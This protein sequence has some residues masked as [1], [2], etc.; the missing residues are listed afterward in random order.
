MVSFLE[1]LEAAAQRNQSLLCVGLD[2]S[3]PQMPIDDIVTFNRAIVEATSDLVCAFKPNI[4]FYEAE[5]LKGLRALE[6]T[7]AAIPGHIPVI[8]DAKRGDIGNSAAA[9]AKAAFERWGADAMTVNAYLGGDSVEPFVAYS[10]RGVFILCRTSNP[11]AAELQALHVTDGTPLYEQVARL[12]AEWNTRGNVGLVVGATHPEELSRV[13]ML[14]PT[15][16]ILVPGV[17]AQG[18]E[19]EASVKAG[20]DANGRRAIVSAS[21]QVLY[22]SSGADY[23]EAARRTAG[24]L[25]DQINAALEGLGHGW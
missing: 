7:L 6:R 23:P 15:M 8:L 10:D 12:A 13:R 1:K 2:P 20:V 24:V 11:G 14:C 18:G 19:L 25:R 22:A 5:G 9:Y 3:P 16:P 4:A 17:G 21:R